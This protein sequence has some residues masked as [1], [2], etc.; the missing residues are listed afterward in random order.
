MRHVPTIQPQQRLAE[1]IVAVP[2]MQ[3]RDCAQLNRSHVRQGMKNQRMEHRVCQ[4]QF[5]VTQG[6]ICQQDSQHSVCLV[7][8]IVGVRG[9]ITLIVLLRIRGLIRVQMIILIHQVCRMR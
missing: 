2:V 7:Q 8:L 5:I 1:N 9:V 4:R 3:R 6:S